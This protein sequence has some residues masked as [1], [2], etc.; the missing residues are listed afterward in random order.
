MV[1]GNTSNGSTWADEV[2]DS[3]PNGGE[4]SFFIVVNDK[5]YKTFLKE[6]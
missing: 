1:N 5:I 4:G 6:N 2:A 3:N